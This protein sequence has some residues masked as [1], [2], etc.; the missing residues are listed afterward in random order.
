[1]FEHVQAVCVRAPHI[2]CLLSLNLTRAT[3]SL[4]L[5]DR[6]KSTSWSSVL[7]HQVV[8]NAGAL[9]GLLPTSVPAAILQPCFV[10]FWHFSL[11]ILI[12]DSRE[13]EGEEGRESRNDMN[14][15]HCDY[16]DNLLNPQASRTSQLLFYFIHQL[17]CRIP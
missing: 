9:S 11:F 16:M 2:L 1:M 14:R 8:G 13:E 3:R 17:H 10:F 15:G 5:V 7:L 12:V 4:L 6:L